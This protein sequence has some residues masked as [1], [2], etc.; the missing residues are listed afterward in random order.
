M[1]V[2]VGFAGRA[3]SPRI[4]SRGIS[5]TA[6]RV[7][8]AAVVRNFRPQHIYIVAVRHRGAISKLFGTGSIWA[9]RAVRHFFALGIGARATT[10]NAA[11]TVPLGGKVHTAGAVLGGTIHQG[12]GL[13]YK[14]RRRTRRLGR[15]GVNRIRAGGVIGK[16][17]SGRVNI[18]IDFGRFRRN[19]TNRSVRSRFFVQTRNGNIR[20][21][22]GVQRNLA[23]NG[24]GEI[25]A[26]PLVLRF[27]LDSGNIVARGQEHTAVAAT[28]PRVG[29]YNL[30]I[31]FHPFYTFAHA[32]LPINQGANDLL[33]TRN[34]AISTGAIGF[35]VIARS[36][37][38]GNT[39]IRIFA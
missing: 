14:R 9:G 27:G 37:K 26:R 2:V 5:S 22:Q 23:R 17:S 31:A 32:R 8:I 15:I 34:C 39:H 36:I 4:K 21:F 16:S 28:V 30:F 3:S 10:F 29:L 35:T 11:Q 18:P 38:N 19:V 12:S 20:Q 13:R 6:Q 1:F 24:A 7:I 33:L 25:N